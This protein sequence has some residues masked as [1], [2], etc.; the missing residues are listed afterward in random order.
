MSLNYCP[1]TFGIFTQTGLL[2]CL[3]VFDM[4]ICLFSETFLREIILL[5]V[6]IMWDIVESKAVRSQD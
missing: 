1:C 6:I 5:T 4:W 3:T 2:G